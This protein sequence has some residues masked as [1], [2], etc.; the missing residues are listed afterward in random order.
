MEIKTCEQY[1]L[2]ELLNAQDEVCL[3]KKEVEELK[4]PKEKEEINTDKGQIFYCNDTWGYYYRIEITNYY[5]YNDIL[6]EN[7]KTPQFL[8]TVLDSDDALR[9]WK[10]M[11]SKGSYFT[12]NVGELQC[13]T[14]HYLFTWQDNAAVLCLS[15]SY[16]S[17][18]FSFYEIDNKRC[19]LDKDLAEKTLKQ[20]ILDEVQAYFKYEHDKKFE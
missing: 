1:V 9:E 14:Y 16:M 11:S 12:R 13:C 18:K 5:N 7:N 19:F 4:A 2:R 6:K 3:L 8:Q 20:N 10:E 17:N 15:D